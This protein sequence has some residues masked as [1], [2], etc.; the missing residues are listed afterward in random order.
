MEGEKRRDL[1]ALR[2]AGLANDP[3]WKPWRD[4]VFT[5]RLYREDY[6]PGSAGQ[7][8]APTVSAVAWIVRYR[9][10]T[11]CSLREAKD[12]FDSGRHMPTCSD[13]ID[14]A[15]ERDARRRRMELAAPQML[16]ALRGAL[17]WMAHVDPKLRAGR[18]FQRNLAS[19]RAAIAAATGEEG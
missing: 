2:E 12:A 10:I 3:N 19:Y 16:E 8:G 9:A 4:P 5:E 11:G 14:D 13:E 18:P 17:E 1:A 15:L 6:A 7:N